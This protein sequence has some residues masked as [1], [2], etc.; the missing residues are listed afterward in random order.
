[1]TAFENYFG[2]GASTLGPLVYPGST[3]Q[4]N[5][6]ESYSDA[7]NQNVNG[8]T[9]AAYNDYKR[10][11]ASGVVTLERDYLGGRLRPL[12]GLQF[13]RVNVHDYTGEEIDGAVMQETRLRSDYLAGDLLG[14]GGGWDNAFK[15]GLTYDTR[16]FEP[17]P[18][19]GMMLQASARLSDKA[20]GSSF[21]YQQVAIS[22][23]PFTICCPTRAV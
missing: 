15:L 9:W 20:L 4:F 17:D 13:T 7:L 19:S 14:F 21:D 8:K 6:F 23:G 1:V 22:V 12:I 16:D 10:T 5:D 3:K 2:T 18:S 11:E